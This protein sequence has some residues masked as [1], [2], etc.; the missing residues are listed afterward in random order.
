MGDLAV[1]VDVVLAAQRGAVGDGDDADAVFRDIDLVELQR[2][3][4][5]VVDHH[6]GVAAG[7]PQ[8]AVAGADD[9]A[10]EVDLAASGLDRV[11]RDLLAGKVEGTVD[12]GQAT[13]AEADARLD[14]ALGVGEVHRAAGIE[15]LVDGQRDAV[16]PALHQT[17]DVQVAGIDVDLAHGEDRGRLG[18]RGNG[19]HQRLQALVAG[20]EAARLGD[21]GVVEQRL[22]E[23]G[24]E[25]QVLARVAAGVVPV[26]GGEV[27]VARGGQ[28]D[29]A[30]AQLADD[31]DA[32]LHV[33]QP[34]Q[35]VFIDEAAD[36]LDVLRRRRQRQVLQR[37]VP[38]HRRGVLG[39]ADHALPGL[40]RRGQR[41]GVEVGGTGVQDDTL[42]VHQFGPAG[43]A[44]ADVVDLQAE[45]RVVDD[46]DVGFAV[47]HQAAVGH[48]SLHAGLGGVTGLDRDQ[49]RRRQ[50][51]RHAQ[52]QRVEAFTHRNAGGATSAGDGGGETELLQLRVDLV[53]QR[54]VARNSLGVAGMADHPASHLGAILEQLVGH[55]GVHQRGQRQVLGLDDVEVVAERHGE[56]QPLVAGHHRQLTPTIGAAVGGGGGV[57]AGGRAG[58]LQPAAGRGAHRVPGGHRQR[59]LGAGEAVGRAHRLPACGVGVVLRLQD[60][61]LLHGATTT[62][63]KTVGLAGHALGEGA[64]HQLDHR[65]GSHRQG[66]I[67]QVERGVVVLLAGIQAQ[68]CLLGVGQ[69]GADPVGRQ[70]ALVVQFIGQ[71]LH[72]GAVVDAGLDLG[73]AADVHPV[74]AG[75]ALVTD[76]LQGHRHR[77]DQRQAV[78]P[79]AVGAADAG[80]GQQVDR[81]HRAHP[82]V[83]GEVDDIVLGEAGRG[84]GQ[85]QAQRDQRQVGL[86]GAQQHIRRAGLVLPGKQLDVVAQQIG[87]PQRDGVVRLQDRVGIG[88]RAADVGHRQHVRASGHA[89]IAAGVQQ[90]IAAEVVQLGAAHLDVRAHVGLL[91]GHGL[92]DG[93]TTDGVHPHL[94]DGLGI[95]VGVDA[96]HTG[97]AGGSRHRHLGAI[98]D[99]HRR[100][101]TAV[102]GA[103]VGG[104]TQCGH[105][106]QAGRA[107]TQRLFGGRIAAIVGLVVGTDGDRA[108][109]HVGLVADL[110]VGGAAERCQHRRAAAGQDADRQV[111]GRGVE[112]LR[113]G[114]PQVQQAHGQVATVTDGHPRAG[115]DVDLRVGAGNA[116]EQAAA[117]G[118]GALEHIVLR[119][120]AQAQ[121]RRGHPHIVTQFGDDAALVGGDDRRHAHGRTRAHAQRVAACIGLLVGRGGD[122]DLAGQQ[123]GQHLGVAHRGAHD[124][125]QRV[126]GIGAG[127]RGGDQAEAGGG[128]QHPG[129]RLRFTEGRDREVLAHAQFGLAGL[130]AGHGGAAAAVDK[131]LG[132]RLDGVVGISAT[133]GKRRADGTGDGHRHRHRLGRDHRLVMRGDADVARRGHQGAV[134][135]GRH[136]AGDGVLGQRDTDGQRATG[137]TEGGR[138]RDGEHPR[139]DGGAVLGID[140]DATVDVDADTGG[141]ADEGLGLRAH[142]VGGAG[143]R[144][145]DGH[146]DGAAGNRHRAGDHQ[147]PHGLRG[148]GQHAQVQRLGAAGQRADRRMVDRGDDAVGRR[149]GQLGPLLRVGEVLGQDQFV[150]L[151]VLVLVH[152][153]QRVAADVL[154]DL[155]G[156]RARVRAQADDVAVGD[157]ARLVHA[158]GVGH[159]AAVAQRVVADVVARQR[160]AD[161]RTDAGGPPHA[162]AQRGGDDQRVDAVGG[163]RLDHDV[164][165][166]A[167]GAV[168]D[169]GQHIAQ[170]HVH[171]RRTGPAHTHAG[172]AAKGRGHRGRPGLDRD[173]GVGAGLDR[174]R[175]ACVE[176]GAGHTGLRHGVDDVARQGHADRDRDTRRAAKRRGDGRCAGMGIDARGVAGHRRDVGHHD[177]AGPRAQ[178]GVGVD[179]GLHP[180][181]DLVLCPHA[182]AAGRHADRPAAGQGRRAGHHQRLDG[183][184]GVGLQA[185]VALGRDVAVDHQRA[186]RG[187][188]RIAHRPKTFLADQV[189]CHRDAD[190]RPHAGI[191]ADRDGGRHRRDAA[192]DR[193]HVVRLDHNIAL[194]GD[195]A[196]AED[197]VGRSHDRVDRHRAGAGH[198]HGGLATAAHRHRRGRRGRVDAVAHHRRLAADAQRQGVGLAGTIV[199]HPALAG[200]DHRDVQ[201]GSLLHPVGGLGVIDLGQISLQ[202]VLADVAVDRTS[203][204]AC[205]MVV[206]HQHRVALAQLAGLGRHL[207]PAAGVG[208]V[209]GAQCQRAGGAVDV[210]VDLARQAAAGHTDHV[211][212]VDLGLA[213]GAA[214]VVPLQAVGAAVL[215][216]RAQHIHR[217]ELQPDTGQCIGHL[218][219]AG[220]GGEVGRQLPHR[221][222]GVVLLPEVQALLVDHL[223]PLVAVEV[224]GGGQVQRGAAALVLEDPAG[225]AAVGDIA[226]HPHQLVLVDLPAALDAGVV[227]RA[228]DVA[229]DRAGLPA[230]GVQGIDPHGVARLHLHGRRGGFIPVAAAGVVQA[231]QVAADIVGAGVGVDAAVGRPRLVTTAQR[232]QSVGVQVIPGLAHAAGARWRHAG[233]CCGIQHLGGH[234][235]GHELRPLQVQQCHPTGLGRDRHI[236]LAGRQFDLADRGQRV[237]VNAVEGQRQADRHRHRV[238]PGE[239]GGNGGRAGRGVDRALVV[240]AQGDAVGR[241]LARCSGGA[242]HCGLLAGPDAVLGIDTG[243]AAGDGILATG[244]HG[245]RR[246]V[247]RRSDGGPAHG[248][249]HQGAG[250]VQRHVVQPRPRGRLQRC[251]A[252]QL[253][254]AGIAV[255]LVEQV[256]AVLVG[257]GV[258]DV[259]VDLAGEHAG[260][261][262]HL[263]ALGQGG[264]L[265][266]LVECR[267]LVVIGHLCSRGTDDVLGHRHAQGHAHAGLGA[268]GHR[269]RHGLH[270]G[271]DVGLVERGDGD[272]ACTAGAA[273]RAQLD[274]AGIGIGLAIDQVERQRAAAGHGRRAAGRGGRHRH[275]GGHAG[276]GDAG[277]A[278]DR[279]AH[280]AA[281]TGLRLAVGRAAEVGG[282]VIADLVARHR[283]AHRDRRR[284]ALRRDGHRNRTRAD[285][286]LDAGHSI[287]TDGQVTAGLQI[288]RVG[289]VGLRLGADLVHGHHRRHRDADGLVLAGLDVDRQRRVGDVGLDVARRRG[290]GQHAAGGVDAGAVGKG[291]GQQGLLGG[292]VAAA[293]GVADEVPDAVGAVTDGVEGQRHAHRGGGRHLAVDDGVDHRVVGRL[294]AHIAAGGGAQAAAA[295][296][297]AGA[298]QHGVGGHHGIE[299][300]VTR[301]DMAFVIGVQDRRLVG[302]HN[303]VA[304]GAGLHRVDMRVHGATQV[305]AHHQP[306]EANSCS[307]VV[308]AAPLPGKFAG[309]RVDHLVEHLEAHF[310]VALAAEFHP[311]ARQEVRL[312]Q[313]DL[314]RREGIAEKPN[315][316][317]AGVAQNE[318][319]E[320]FV[321]VVLGLEVDIFQ[322]CGP[323]VFIDL[324]G[325]ASAQAAHQLHTLTCAHQLGALVGLVVGRADLHR[326]AIL[327]ALQA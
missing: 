232:R 11:E 210:A 188:G 307:L 297:G 195:G 20:G 191:A 324:V 309:C 7:H 136:A 68:R 46:V 267:G 79:G 246:G 234:A 110:D 3:A 48:R 55:V 268:Q 199:D 296:P 201:G 286:G 273:Q 311:R 194:G 95:G 100:A 148:V 221:G 259:L 172:R 118:G 321:G 170:D 165:R 81:A 85:A 122:L 167:D 289:D 133:A 154:V 12:G 287:G 326:L 89:G 107:R 135:E 276:A 261:L 164:R 310:A 17:V 132:R 45:R 186:R 269:G 203:H 155:V 18:R 83:A 211:I 87:T 5:L 52:G 303:Q 239:R 30:G 36:H 75:H 158:R 143:A 130:A 177:A 28:L 96:E 272:V 217:R 253:P 90:Q 47:G 72:H 157:L 131:G 283:K 179:R 2:K 151:A 315:V 241:E 290:I 42:A 256:D 319:P 305:V 225:E 97:L 129:L 156:A 196:A 166:G 248:G 124:W 229:V 105:A 236:A 24:V 219:Q 257:E 313:I 88:T 66:H 80:F 173:A 264:E 242:V 262:E 25:V 109:Q 281:D 27:E 185:Q 56:G 278:V 224:V 140:G 233:V 39:D 314:H 282:H 209:L 316:L 258:A 78:G 115:L 104:R 127:R 120:G 252:Q 288:G 317:L 187:N 92:G 220:G 300:D 306:T 169:L 40:G 291:F 189:A 29:G 247:D 243:S 54:L 279:D 244:G 240:G 280:A 250:G 74:V 245:H 231:G 218:V 184:L 15:T 249:D 93:V 183:L 223:L 70:L 197:G 69:V 149:V 32:A 16:D 26:V 76:R 116:E 171:R 31:V 41:P 38:G 9:G 193:R 147:R 263:L 163:Q 251:V 198:G 153:Q 146:A 49:T 274:L 117:G 178:H 63:H 19:V 302:T 301:F 308:A 327:H 102:G 108:G 325:L 86:G 121:H 206:G 114:G 295:G 128:R 160:H 123:V 84:D 284:I 237:A 293:E 137:G 174:D 190:G 322:A 139:V 103:D 64:G 213:L 77:G 1:L 23:G 144:T 222:V 227:H 226:V 141:V 255:A 265:V 212:L 230:S 98:A 312:V 82:G 142:A 200:L 208:V 260:V 238:L 292:V 14:L 71:Q 4:G 182:R 271:L 61:A 181:A 33:G 99:H 65:A 21:A 35:P 134:D 235:Q 277:A 94:V 215:G 320:R 275:R 294:Q 111:L 323:D 162:H 57:V 266:D 101:E 299:A 106:G 13:G 6:R 270:V 22:A 59:G 150:E 138:H 318:P 113:A 161:G 125:C 73:L 216:G 34:Q 285:F 254:G 180:H 192:G 91:V 119:G 175:A 62:G 37:G 126:D 145:A 214:A 8:P 152:R 228:A 202:V 51:G 112:V 58:A 207:L 168:V 67:L 176:L 50:D 10:G 205:G 298:A 304:G 53:E 43:L 60:E 159:R 44:D 204:A